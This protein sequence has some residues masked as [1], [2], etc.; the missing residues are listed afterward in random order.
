[1][2]T[3]AVPALL[4]GLCGG[5]R[6]L[7]VPGAT[8]GAVLRAL[9]ERCPG[10]YDRVVED[11]HLRPELAFAIDGEVVGLALHDVVSADAEIAIVPAIGG[12]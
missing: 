12:G 4:R 8:F 2:A 10:I 9:D 5:A 1:M 7:D 6:H 11:G 3:V